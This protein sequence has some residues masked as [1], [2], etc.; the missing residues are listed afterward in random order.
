LEEEE[1][2]KGG[3]IFSFSFFFSKEDLFLLEYDL[4]GWKI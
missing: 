1:K 2:K 3:E 4:L